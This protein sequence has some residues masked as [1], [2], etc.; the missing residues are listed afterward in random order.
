MAKGC[1]VYR[2]RRDEHPQHLLNTD[3]EYWYART[4]QGRKAAGNTLTDVAL[5]PI[6][7]VRLMAA[8][9]ARGY[10]GSILRSELPL[11]TRRFGAS[12]VPT[13]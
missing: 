5:S 3:Q 1:G 4:K 6:Y 10:L 11:R 9:N 12:D 7:M 13:R 2:S 8:A